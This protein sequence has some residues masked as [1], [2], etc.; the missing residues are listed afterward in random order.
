MSENC[1]TV[2]SS[3]SVAE[4][5]MEFICQRSDFCSF[6]RTFP[7]PDDVTWWTDSRTTVVEPLNYDSYAAT[8]AS[9]T[10]VREGDAWLFVEAD[11]LDGSGA[12]GAA[13]CPTASCGALVTYARGWPQYNFCCPTGTDLVGKLYVY[14]TIMD[15]SRLTSMTFSDIQVS[16]DCIEDGNDLRCVPGLYDITVTKGLSCADGTCD[17]PTEG[18]AYGDCGIPGRCESGTDARQLETDLAQVAVT[19][20]PQGIVTTPATP[21]TPSTAPPTMGTPAPTA[22]GVN[23]PFAVMSMPWI[24]L[25][26]VLAQLR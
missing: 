26:W 9:V 5:N 4:Y 19:P 8:H 25:F 6:S 24:A 7:R 21:A 16:P 20:A 11:V 1:I 3:P 15:G 23:T 2:G 18:Q 22:S 17:F 10:F 13:T 14:P 12:Y